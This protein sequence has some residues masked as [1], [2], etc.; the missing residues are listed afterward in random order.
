LS[1]VVIVRLHTTPWSELAV[2]AAIEEIAADALAH[3]HPDT[4]WPGPPSDDGVNLSGVRPIQRMGK[5]GPETLAAA[6][7]PVRR[8]HEQ[9]L[10]LP[11]SFAWGAL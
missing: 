10:N 9:Q 5:G 3:L 7:R 2:Q 8:A 6:T 1:L 4:F 11:R